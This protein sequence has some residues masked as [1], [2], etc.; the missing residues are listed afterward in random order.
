MAGSVFI[1]YSR[2][3]RA[4]VEKLARHLAAVGVPVWYD[5]ELTVGE[6]FAK[7]VSDRI[8]A[9]CA[10]IVVLS[11]GSCRSKW[12]ARE[13][14]YAA[15]RDKPILP[16]LLAPCDVPIYVSD[17]HREDVTG[18]R[19]PGDR[20]TA[21]LRAA[22]RPTAD[23]AAAKAPKRAAPPT[24]V[25][26][27]TAVITKA[28]GSCNPL[29]LGTAAHLIRT[30]APDLV[31]QRWGGSGRCAAFV[32]DRLPAFGFVPDGGGYLWLASGPKPKIP[33][34][35]APTIAS[36]P[37][38]QPSVPPPTK[39]LPVVPAPRRPRPLGPPTRS[40]LAQ[41][42]KAL[43]KALLK[44]QP[45]SLG[46]AAATVRKAAPDVAMTGAVRRSSRPSWTASSPSTPTPNATA[47]TCGRRRRRGGPR[48]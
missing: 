41:I 18:G 27:I 29:P 24:D 23:R 34:S 19:M 43:E 7:E 40:E 15:E 28:L 35:A 16:I 9:C 48:C 10:L 4:Y 17:L 2:T 25:E 32:R 39:M 45:L 13:V 22:A 6:R 1:S 3:D 42:R 14:H 5:I 47:A 46:I 21:R 8:R 26:R 31:A 38:K 11:P 12:V 37:P 44:H 33:A 30:V 20:F 36:P